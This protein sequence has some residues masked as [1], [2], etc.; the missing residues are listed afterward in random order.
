MSNYNVGKTI[1][2]LVISPYYEPA[3]VYGGPAKSIPA[4][5][6]SLARNGASVTVFTTNSN[7]DKKLR[8]I[9]V[10]RMLIQ[11][12]VKVYYFSRFT[13]SSYFLSLNLLLACIN[14]IPN[15]DIIQIH[16]VF[17]FLSLVGSILSR[18][19][20][21]TYVV[22]LHGMLM[23]WAYQY[24][25]LKKSFYMKMIERR[26]LC[27][28]QALISTDVFEKEA[29]EK[30]NFN[31]PIINIPYGVD[32]VRYKVLPPRGKLRKQLNIPQ[33]HSIILVLGRLHPVKRPDLAMD[34]FS[35]VAQKHPLSHLVFAGPDETQMST[36]IISRARQAGF[37]K[38]VHFTGLLSPDQVIQML[39]DADIFL[40]TS[41]SENFGMAI[42][43]AMAAG[44]PVIVSNKIGL[45][46]IVQESNGGLSC[47]LNKDSI[48]Y[49]L[50][51]LLE[52]PDQLKVIGLK[53]RQ[54]VFDRY[55]IN[56]V[57][58]KILETYRNLVGNFS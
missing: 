41:E 28:A 12:K 22:F 54:Y 16:G 39:S 18:L 51:T 49:K 23:P 26:L 50:N 1:K 53:G 36:G 2:I 43:E 37:E 34:A 29:L 38:R 10:N 7:G 35:L 24:K 44:L 21:K 9:P 11:E 57:A 3:N 33:E 52:K 20:K 46:R 14:Q 27:R 42:V 31:I 48:A 40:N 25:H 17:S 6:K 58:Q 15:F 30:F 45:A 4:L 8:D 55:E 32:F 19:Y 13:R 47:D 5:C 56:Q